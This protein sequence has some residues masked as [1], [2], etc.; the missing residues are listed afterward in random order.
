MV[1]LDARRAA[2]GELETG[3]QIL[4]DVQISRTVCTVSSRIYCIETADG[5]SDICRQILCQISLL[6][7]KL[8][9]FQYFSFP[10]GFAVY[11]K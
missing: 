3:E 5:E 8:V 10:F 7:S 6:I 4:Q 2:V 9:N 1:G 11:T